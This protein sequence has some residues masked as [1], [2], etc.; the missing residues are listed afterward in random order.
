MAMLSMV[1]MGYVLTY[2]IPAKQKSVIFPIHS[3]R[4]LYLAQ[5]GI[6]FAARYAI[7]NGWTTPVTL[8]NLDS[9][10]RNLGD[11][12]GSF[13]LNYDQPTNKLTSTGVIPGVSQRSIAVSNFTTFLTSPTGLV[14]DPG[15]PSPCGANGTSTARFT[16]RNGSDS[17]VTLAYFSASWAGGR[18]LT[19]ISMNGVPKFS[20]NLGSPVA[21]TVLDLGSQTIS[22]DGVVIVVLTW[23][24]ILSG[25]NIIFTLYPGPAGG[26]YIF[27]LDP[28]GAGLPG[29]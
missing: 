25:S 4:S 20:G 17:S 26:G 28:G 12:N 8:N 16:I 21:R 24:G 13:T 7:A 1:A 29:C 27:Y 15:S 9:V 3:T 19:G 11:R 22:A 23:S 6:E 5:S 18:N 2:L 14:L 10:T